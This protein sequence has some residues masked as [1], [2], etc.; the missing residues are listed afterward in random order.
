MTLSSHKLSTEFL[1]C[2]APFR[3]YHTGSSAS[4]SSYYQ[5]LLLSHQ[6]SSFTTSMNLLC[7]PPLFLLPGSSPL[8]ILCPLYP[9]SLLRT[10]KPLH[11]SFSNFRNIKSWYWYSLRFIAFL[12]LN[13]LKS[14]I[15]CG[16][17]L[18]PCCVSLHLFGKLATL[19][20]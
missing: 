8:H 3:S 20:E 9:L 1:L 12:N 2:S 18:E 6:P 13:T 7:I 14:K 17:Q 5:H 4:I 19:K 11:P 16:L 15:Y 10:S